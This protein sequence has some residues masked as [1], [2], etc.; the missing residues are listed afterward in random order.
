MHNALI[1][2]IGKKNSPLKWTLKTSLWQ[3]KALSIIRVPLIGA[4]NKI[5]KKVVFA[6]EE[7]RV[8]LLYIYK[9]IDNLDEKEA[10]EL[11]PQVKK[12]R[13]TIAKYSSKFAEIDHADTSQVCD[14]FDGLLR[15]ANRVESKA[16]K[17]VY[18]NKKS[19]NIESPK[20]KGYLGE[21]TKKAFA[22]ASL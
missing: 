8:L 13:K 17:Q 7:M 11:Y 2:N 22:N 4:M 19:Q 5:L 21:N 9:D 12:I 20:I 1:G 6:L 18:S 14:K 3:N 16:R 15:I 10:K